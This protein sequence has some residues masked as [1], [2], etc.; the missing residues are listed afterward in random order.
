MQTKLL[1][2][3]F[4]TCSLAGSIEAQDSATP[5]S[6]AVR[7]AADRAATNFVTAA[8]EMPG[9]KYGFKPTRAQ[10][11]FGD[12]IAH[13][14][15]GNDALCSSIG[16]VGPPKRSAVAAGAQKERLVERLRVTFQFCRSALAKL[17]DSRLGE[18]VPYFGDQELSRAQVMLAA[19]EEWGGHYSQLAVY[20]RLN[21][22]V[23]PSARR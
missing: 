7:S 4:A 6:D 21:G 14:S 17:N 12:V 3:G 8:E 1:L 16:G 23:P 9:E 15:A 18:K 10:M 20:L 22:L 19:A 2:I 5:V 11:S 13:M